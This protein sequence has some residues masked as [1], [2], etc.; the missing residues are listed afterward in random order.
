MQGVKIC[1]SSRI[2]APD[3]TGSAFSTVC[4]PCPHVALPPEDRILSRWFEDK[5]SEA[6]NKM[7]QSFRNSEYLYKWHNP[8]WLKSK[9]NPKEICRGKQD[10]LPWLQSISFNYLLICSQMVLT[11][12]TP[13]FMQPVNCVS[14]IVISVW[15]NFLFWSGKWAFGG[16]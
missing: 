12:P 11:S 14:G 3:G 5:I 2:C 16:R 7:S 10:T 6:K 9:V 13:S 1:A 15:N 8:K 4:L